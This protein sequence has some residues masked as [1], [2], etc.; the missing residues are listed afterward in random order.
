MA[1]ISEERLAQLEGQLQELLRQKAEQ[2]EQIERLKLREILAGIEGQDALETIVGELARQVDET[3][4]VQAVQ[5]EM[6]ADMFPPEQPIA[7]VHRPPPS[8]RLNTM[9]PDEFSALLD[10]LNNWVDNI[11]RPQ[12]GFLAAMLDPCWAKHGLCLRMLDVLSEID[13]TDYIQPRRDRRKLDQ[14]AEFYIR[15]LYTAANIMAE[16]TADCRKAQRHMPR[17]VR[18]VAIGPVPSAPAGGE[19][20]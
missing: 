20:A 1:E 14:Q 19:A 5:V 3:R 11:Y 13:L 17:Q 7:G 2:R 4:E 10:R 12:F 15:Q 16:E 9:T 6:W 18:P 8:P